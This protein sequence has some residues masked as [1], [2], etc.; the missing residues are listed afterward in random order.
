MNHETQLRIQGYLDGELSRQDCREVEGLLRTTPEARALAE[1]LKHVGGLLREA[2][3]PLRVP[4]RR[5]FYWSKIE[6]G[7]RAAETAAARRNFGLR[8]WFRIL[9]PAAGLAMLLLLAM[10][11]VRHGL[12]ARSAGYGRQVESFGE[13]GM[14]SSM[15]TFRSEAESV[16]VVWVE[17]GWQLD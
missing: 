5:E 17:H 15:F 8:Y 13:G 16:T 12:L 1:D 11:Q 3:R 10:P 6:R 14:E 2:E 7:I 9:A 4:E